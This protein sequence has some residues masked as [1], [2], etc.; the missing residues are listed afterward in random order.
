MVSL[1]QTC[2]GTAHGW[3]SEVFEVQIDSV[4]L[5]CGV[6]GGIVLLGKATVIRGVLGLHGGWMGGKQYNIALWQDD[7]YFSLHPFQLF[8]VGVYLYLK[9]CSKRTSLIFLDGGVW[10]QNE[11]WIKKC[12]RWVIIGGKPSE[13]NLRFGYG[14]R[15]SFW[16]VAP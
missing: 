1:D 15:Y 10:I 6:V 13:S 16:L 12:W 5:F 11:R 7:Q 14:L 4:G 3:G 8:N 9:F 2:P